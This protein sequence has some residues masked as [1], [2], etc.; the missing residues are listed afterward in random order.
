M[1]YRARIKRS[2]L[3]FRITVISKGVFVEWL[4]NAKTAYRLQADLIDVIK[5]DNYEDLLIDY[6]ADAIDALV[7]DKSIEKKSIPGW[8]YG[9]VCGNVQGRLEVAWYNKY[10]IEAGID[11]KNIMKIKAVIEYLKFDA[12]LLDKIGKIYSYLIE[13]KVQTSVEKFDN[14]SNVVSIFK[15]INKSNVMIEDFKGSII[16]LL[17]ADVENKVMALLNAQHYDCCPDLDKYLNYNDIL[18]IA[19]DEHFA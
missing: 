18:Q 8:S 3:A 14:F 9:Y 4:E 6:L 11:Y 2:P 19:G 15:N 5:N 12:L 7:T 17:S 13:Q 1:D 16:A 10:I